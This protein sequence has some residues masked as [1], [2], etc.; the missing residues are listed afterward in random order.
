MTKRVEDMDSNSS[1]RTQPFAGASESPMSMAES[2][3]SMGV[4]II[5][6][7]M[8]LRDAREGGE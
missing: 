7:N 1:P 4:D 2:P 3:V 5:F 8:N 6:S